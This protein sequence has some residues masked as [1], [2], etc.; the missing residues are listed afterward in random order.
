MSGRQ[1]ICYM[2]EGKKCPRCGSTVNTNG[3]AVWCSFVGDQR[4]NIPACSYGLNVNI[5]LE[6]HKGITQRDD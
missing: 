4:N 2:L 1:E 6:E 3:K 5:T